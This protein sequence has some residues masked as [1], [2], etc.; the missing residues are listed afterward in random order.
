APAGA[1]ASRINTPGIT[2]WPGKWP[3]KKGS[4]IVTFFT[5]TIRFASSFSITLS[6]NKNGYRCGIISLISCASNI[7][8]PAFHVF[9]FVLFH[10]LIKQLF[11]N[12]N[13][14]FFEKALLIARRDSTSLSLHL[15]LQYQYYVAMS[16]YPGRQ[17]ALPLRVHHMLRLTQV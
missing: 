15:F 10:F 7:C 8:I 13:K 3:W 11:M 1:S 2:G 4:L 16:L 14:P 12:F 17:V 5:P 9:V 6:T